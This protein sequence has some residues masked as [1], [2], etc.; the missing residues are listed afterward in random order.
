MKR[1]L[2]PLAVMIVAVLF[3]TPHNVGA[4]C[5]EDTVDLG[6]CDTLYIETFD[7]DH[8]YEAE[9]GSFDSVR[10]AIYVTHDSNSFWWEGGEKYVQDSIAFFQ[11]PLVFWHQPEGCADSVIFPDWDHWNNTA[12]NPYDPRMSRSMFRHIVDT[13]T[14]DT[15]FN[16]MLRMVENYHPAWEVYTDI[17]SHSSDGDSGHVFLALVPT[18]SCQRWG[19]GS[20]ELLATLTF[21]VYMSDTCDC[22]EICLDSMFWSPASR[23]VFTR[24]DAKNYTPRHFLPVKDTICTTPTTSCILGPPCGPYNFGSGIAG[25]AYDHSRGLFYQVEVGTP[26]GIFAWDPITCSLEYPP[27]SLVPWALPQRGI[28]YRPDE[29]VIYVGGWDEGIIY[30]TTPPPYCELIDTFDMNWHPY[31]GKIS[32][33][34][35][36]DDYGG[37]V[38]ASKAVP[39]YLGKIDFE[40]KELIWDSPMFWC[41]DT[42][43]DTSCAGLSYSAGYLVSVNT[44]QNSVEFFL[45]PEFDA[46]EAD[47]FCYLP[48]EWLVG[49]VGF[50]ES[51]VPWV[52]DQPGYSNYSLTT[53]VDSV[54]RVIA[55]IVLPDDSASLYDTVRIALADERGQI[56]TITS[57]LFEYSPNGTDWYYIGEDF[58]GADEMASSV[59]PDTTVGDGWS[60]YWWTGSLSEGWY[61]IRGTFYTE[62]GLESSDRISVHVDSTPAIPTILSPEFEAAV[63]ESVEIHFTITDTTGI[64]SVVGAIARADFDYNKEVPK[65]RQRDYNPGGDTKCGPTAAASCLWYW[66]RHGFAGLGTSPRLRRALSDEEMV[67][68]LAQKMRWRHPGG[69]AWNNLVEGIKKYIDQRGFDF[70]FEEY[71]RPGRRAKFEDYK[72]ELERNREDVILLLRRDEPAQGHYVTGNSLKNR[73]N[74]DGT[75]DID[76]MDPWRGDAPCYY[77]SKWDDIGD[78]EESEVDYSFAGEP[79]RWKVRCMVSV[80]PNRADKTIPEIIKFRLYPPIQGEYHLKFST[81]EMLPGEIWFLSVQ[82][83]KTFPGLET[84]YEDYITVVKLLRGDAN[85]DGV[86]NSADVV[87]LINYLFKGGPAPEPLEAGDVNCDGIINSADVVYLI[88]YLFKGG[89]PPGCD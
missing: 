60:G 67:N 14:G 58:D 79:V 56:E 17:E 73:R 8:A 54:P 74:A 42:T 35:W 44:S 6:I 34:A 3:F 52:S 49:G 30:K 26:G 55:M 5:P 65:F 31:L 19:E 21:H 37:L 20:R 12:M 77:Q 63:G 75:W 18:G 87:Y 40:N 11:V 68:E 32:G 83:Y 80:S 43:S 38:I 23:L 61:I 59:G 28:A 76:F 71:R 64:D 27:C 15:T 1:N 88:N 86:I 29:D 66:S 47:T 41:D 78:D 39:D 45:N 69:V 62:F 84:L 2:L 24:Y 89:P 85:G 7:C 51:L 50:S 81:E 36:D 53:L 33:L 10:V 25:M 70:K 22:T 46:F 16:R 13:H 82:A 48:L 4:Q 9:P 57:A 72:R